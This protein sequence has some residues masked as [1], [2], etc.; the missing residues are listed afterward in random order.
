MPRRYEVGSSVSEAYTSVEALYRQTY[1]EVINYVVQAVHSKFNHDRYKNLSTL[2]E[3]PC[4]H[5]TNLDDFNHLLSLQ[6]NDLDKVTSQ[7]SCMFYIAKLQNKLK[8]RKAASII[9]A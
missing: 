5:K 9:R 2:E 6:V 4:D 7:Q 3:L 1:Y 8:M